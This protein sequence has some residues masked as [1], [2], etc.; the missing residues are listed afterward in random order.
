MRVAGG[1]AG[2]DQSSGQVEEAGLTEPRPKGHMVS[3]GA[4]SGLRFKEGPVS[5]TH[6]GLPPLLPA[7]SKAFASNLQ[8]LS[9]A[10]AAVPGPGKSSGLQV[11]G[12]WS[13][14]EGRTMTGTQEM[15]C[16]GRMSWDHRS[17]AAL[18]V[19]LGQEGAGGHCQLR[20]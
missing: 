13:R 18:A 19:Q 4:R 7:E 8:T 20:N 15:A 14:E 6:P 16:R 17:E 2:A 10:K 5:L 9:V 12:P 3:C 11:R 1:E